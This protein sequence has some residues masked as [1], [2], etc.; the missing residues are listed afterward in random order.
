MNVMVP[1]KADDP[2]S[3][4]PSWFLG[5]QQKIVGHFERVVDRVLD[6]LDIIVKIQH[7]HEEAIA[8]NAREIAELS[9]R[10]SGEL[11]NLKNRQMANEHALVNLQERSATTEETSTT[12]P[13]PASTVTEDCHDDCEVR[14]SGLPVKLNPCDITNVKHVL[15]ALG[16][17]R[18]LPHVIRVREWKAK[19][20]VSAANSAISQIDTA[21]K[22]TPDTKACVL[23]FASANARESF[24]AAAPRFQRLPVSKIFVLPEAEDGHLSAA[25]IL[26]PE[27]Y[28]LLRRCWLLRKQH[29]LPNPVVRNMRTYMHGDSGAE[30]DENAATTL[31][32]ASLVPLMQN[33]NKGEPSSLPLDPERRGAGT[34]F[35]SRAHGCTPSLDY[36]YEAMSPTPTLQ[37]CVQCASNLE[38]AADFAKCSS[39]AAPAHSHCVPTGDRVFTCGACLSASGSRITRSNSCSSTSSARSTSQKRSL[40]SPDDSAVITTKKVKHLATKNMSTDNKTQ[41]PPNNRDKSKVVPS[42]K[43]PTKGPPEWFAEFD[44][45]VNAR[46]D[47]IDERLDTFAQ[48]QYDQDVAI[49]TNTAHIAELNER[50]S[51]ELRE[52]QQRHTE[53]GQALAEIREEVARLAIAAVTG[54]VNRVAGPPSSTGC[55][56]DCEVRLSSIPAQLHPCDRSTV[57]RVLTA[58]EER[59]LLPHVLRIREWNVKRHAP[60]TASGEAAAP[61]SSPA[62][63][64]CVIR[65]ALAVARETFLAAAPRFQRLPVLQIFELPDAGDGRLSASPILPIE[66]YKLLKKCWT[67]RK[68]HHLPN[69][70]IRNMRTYMWRSGNK[71]LTAIGCEAALSAF[72]AGLQQSSTPSGSASL[73]TTTS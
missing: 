69:P 6:R 62:T 52:I 35:R 39:C 25:P 55:L 12:V 2:D 4:V 27:R 41:K 53:D 51:S 46:L 7:K 36:R 68:Q 10:L 28:R 48:R 57:E 16:E 70:I 38:D 9:R 34:V 20:R 32:K 64:A 47:H 67:V 45:R 24:L 72:A 49:A 66:S 73:P 29:K 71:E 43:K 40:S 19:P 26:P 23:R 65:F 5:F 50:M 30:A 59:E 3:T 63:V 44:Q 11:M 31:K 61:S 22:H 33:L 18:L 60:T 13:V 1:P 37:V 21:A 58:L 14:L 56:E 42:A 17:E 8:Q 15:E 54:A